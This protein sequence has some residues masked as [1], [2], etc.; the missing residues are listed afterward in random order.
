MLPNIPAAKAQATVTSSLHCR[1][2]SDTHSGISR[3]KGSVVSLRQIER[4]DWGPFV[5]QQNY[6]WRQIFTRAELNAERPE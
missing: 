3:T 5:Q 6:F 2:L 1:I 4:T